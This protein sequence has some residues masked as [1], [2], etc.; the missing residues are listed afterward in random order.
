MIHLD[1]DG[2]YEG[3]LLK[4]GNNSVIIHFSSLLWS[5]RSFDIAELAGA[6]LLFRNVINDLATLKVFPH[7]FQPENVILHFSLTRSTLGFNFSSFICFICYEKTR[8]PEHEMACQ[9]IIQL[10][11]SH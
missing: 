3:V 2:R 7:F 10:F 6:F 1:L 5:Y 8:E 9:L 4:D 11:L